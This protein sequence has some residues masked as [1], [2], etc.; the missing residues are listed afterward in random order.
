VRE[1]RGHT[2]AASEWRPADFGLEAC[3]PDELRVD[4]P[5]GS[6]AVIRGILNGTD[7]PPR[8]MVLANAAAALLAA[9]RVPTLL[10]GVAQ[11]GEALASGRARRVLERLLACSRDGM[12]GD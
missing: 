2:V 6:A 12:S 8:R 1:V 11:A 4:G 7:G 10:E 3:A 9:E 5:K